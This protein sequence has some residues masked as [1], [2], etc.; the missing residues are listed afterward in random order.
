MTADE[1]K[2]KGVEDFQLNY[3]IETLARQQRVATKTGAR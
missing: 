3:A 1:L 2:A